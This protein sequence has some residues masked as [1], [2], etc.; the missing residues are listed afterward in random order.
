MSTDR[1][2]YEFNREVIYTITTNILARFNGYA[3]IHEFGK[4]VV[5]IRA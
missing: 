1:K 4:S 5:V 2:F 3:Y